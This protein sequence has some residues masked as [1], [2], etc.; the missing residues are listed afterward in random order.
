MR[1]GLGLPI[2]CLNAS[3]KLGLFEREH[4]YST[5]Q[6]ESLRM[7]WPLSHSK[8]LLS[9]KADSSCSRFSGSLVSVIPFASKFPT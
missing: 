8:S 9:P 3:I 6:E 2:K 4:L 7:R 1:L 5:T